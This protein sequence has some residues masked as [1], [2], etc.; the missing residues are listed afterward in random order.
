MQP[1]AAEPRPLLMEMGIHDKCFLIED[2]LKGY[3]GVK[4]IYRA[5]GAAEKLW[6]DI[7]PGPHAFA[8]N[9]AFRFFR[10]YL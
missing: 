10:E 3:E 2:K 1:A 5:A 8:G 7:H 9:K 4:R 6:V